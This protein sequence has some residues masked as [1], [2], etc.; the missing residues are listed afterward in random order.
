MNDINWISVSDSL[1]DRTQIVLAC[2][3]DLVEHILYFF[4]QYENGIWKEWDKQE[5]LEYKI[6]HWFEPFPPPDME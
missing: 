1:P 2:S 3:P 6:T 5:A 4:V